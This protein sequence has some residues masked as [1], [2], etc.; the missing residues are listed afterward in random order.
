MPTANIQN[1][2]RLLLLLF[3]LIAVVFVIRELR[4][5]KTIRMTDGK[6]N[7]YTGEF[8]T[9]YFPKRRKRGSASEPSESTPSEN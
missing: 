7:I 6:G 8:K 2:F 4:A 3:V 9:V 5:K 1:T